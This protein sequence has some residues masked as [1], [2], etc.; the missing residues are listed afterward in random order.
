[1]ICRARLLLEFLMCPVGMGTLTMLV[2]GAW[3]LGY[4]ALNVLVGIYWWGTS[5]HGSSAPYASRQFFVRWVR[6]FLMAHIR[7]GTIYCV[8]AKLAYPLRSVIPI[9][10]FCGCGSSFCAYSQ[11]WMEVVQSR[12]PLASIR[13]LVARVVLIAH[14]SRV[15]LPIPLPLLPPVQRFLP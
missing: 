1:M 13:S 10:I 8:V 2:G 4:T 12:A 7:C 11:G 15:L 3:L 6:S 5:C 9:P 14:C